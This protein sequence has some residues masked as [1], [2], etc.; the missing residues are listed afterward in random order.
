MRSWPRRCTRSGSKGSRGR[1]RETNSSTPEPLSIAL[2]HVR[3]S[4]HLRKVTGR[5]F[6]VTAIASA[7]YPAGRRDTASLGGSIHDY[8]P[9]RF[10]A[11]SFTAPGYRDPKTVIR[12]R[13]RTTNIGRFY[14]RRECSVER[15]SRPTHK[16]G[17]N[18]DGSARCSGWGGKAHQCETG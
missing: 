12:A 7:P 14:A 3:Y 9:S 1:R 11:I 8:L 6:V 13:M 2:W 5:L 10:L 18:L 4:G 16:R 17:L 15:L